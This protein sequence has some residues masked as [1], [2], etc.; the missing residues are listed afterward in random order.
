MRKSIRKWVRKGQS[1]VLCMLL[2][3]LVLWAG[4]LPAGNLKCFAQESP[5]KDME[6]E[7]QR[8]GNDSTSEVY[9]N[10]DTGY[11]VWMEDRA[12]LLTKEQ[13]MELAKAMEE[14]TSYGNAAFVTTKENARSTESFARSCYMEQFGTDSGTIFVID[15]DNRN[16]WIH[17]DGAVYK[18]IT[19]S[20]ANTITDNVYRYASREDYY[21]CAKEAFEEIY[22]LLEGQ[23]IAQP[24][25]YISNALLAM[26]LAML[27]NFGLIICFTRLHKPRR[28]TVL[29]NMNR[30]F[31]YSNL[32]AD[33]AYQTKIY[34]PISS[35]GGGSGGGSHGGGGRGG[36][37]GG[38]SGGGGG[39]SF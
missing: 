34:D 9:R 14:I 36:G 13:E 1:R 10:P 3:V 31:S 7:S 6:Y 12:E 17:S 26:I 16:I 29:E 32:K 27:A 25:K 22:A 11:R 4:V 28:K 39:H 21:G 38:H 33:Y 15:M 18:V 30:K 2:S 23:K 35:G 37:G 19:K 5:K 24:M 20:Y 8:D